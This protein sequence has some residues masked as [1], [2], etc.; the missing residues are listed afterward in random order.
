MNMPHYAWNSLSILNEC[1]CFKP[2]YGRVGP[3]PFS[4]NARVQ[5]LPRLTQ[6]FS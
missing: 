3:Y 1:L 6:L 5:F 2:F 4:E